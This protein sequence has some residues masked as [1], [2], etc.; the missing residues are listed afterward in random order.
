MRREQQEE[1]QS[2]GADEKDAASMDIADQE[3]RDEEVKGT[4]EHVRDEEQADG[5]VC[6]CVRSAPWVKHRENF[7][8]SRRKSAAHSQCHPYTPLLSPP[9]RPY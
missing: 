2:E 8:H 6:V 1:D 9:S 5:Q 3:D 7:N 4:V